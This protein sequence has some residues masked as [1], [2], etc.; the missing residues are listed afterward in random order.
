[1]IPAVQRSTKKYKE[2]CNEAKIGLLRNV[3]HDC[4]EENNN[5][6]EQC[7]HYRNK[8]ENCINQLNVKENDPSFIVNGFTTLK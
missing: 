1:M 6:I 4:L 7:Q 3:F 2:D 8:L 5:K